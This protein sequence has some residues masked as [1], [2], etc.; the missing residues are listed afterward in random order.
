MCTGDEL[1]QAI[2]DVRPS[3]PCEAE[4][5]RQNVR[6]RIDQPRG[7]K[8]LP[9]LARHERSPFSNYLIDRAEQHLVG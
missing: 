2:V 9:G 1:A 4:H 8:L 6:K 5:L 7:W 3:G